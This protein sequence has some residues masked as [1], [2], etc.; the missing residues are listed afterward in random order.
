M[1]HLC[2]SLKYYIPYQLDF[3]IKI[4]LG[5]FLVD[6]FAEYFAQNLQASCNGWAWIR[7]AYQVYKTF[8]EKNS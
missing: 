7:T 3:I 5:Y 2:L 6:I 1:N 4:N 8:M